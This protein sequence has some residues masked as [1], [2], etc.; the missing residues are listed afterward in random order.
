MQCKYG[1]KKKDNAPQSISTNDIGAICALFNLEGPLCRLLDLVP[2]TI[3]KILTFNF[4]SGDGYGLFDEIILKVTQRTFGLLIDQ[5]TGRIPTELFCSMEPPAM[6]EDITYS[7]VFIFMADLVPI[8]SNFFATNDV[9]SGNNTK[10]LDKIVAAWLRQQWFEHCECKAPPPVPD[11]NAY[12]NTP[13]TL[14]CGNSSQ[15]Q[16]VRDLFESINTFNQLRVSQ[17]KSANEVYRDTYFAQ[18]KPQAIAA[19]LA[20]DGYDIYFEDLADNIPPINTYPNTIPYSCGDV[21]VELTEQLDSKINRYVAHWTEGGQI[22]YTSTVPPYTNEQT[23]QNPS[24]TKLTWIEDCARCAPPI[25]SPV[26]D[27]NLFPK[28][29]FCALFPNDPL[30]GGNGDDDNNGECNIEYVICGEAVACFPLRRPIRLVLNVTGVDTSITVTEFASCANPR[31]TVEMFLLECVTP[32]INDCPDYEAALI[33]IAT[34]IS[35]NR[36][37]R[38]VGESEYRDLADAIYG[39]YECENKQNNFYIGEV[40]NTTYWNIK[41][42][43]PDYGCTDVFAVNYDPTA[44]HDDGSCQY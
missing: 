36:I 29:K 33:A 39:Q 21:F 16:A 13:P 32:V 44:S 42:A 24:S 14:R 17:A 35:N 5:L 15:S 6:P 28:D 9:L 30:C 25:P 26:L 11:S 27:G 3:Q 4:V 38:S 41:N 37:I 8:L 43:N 34:N 10:L 31:I 18:A 1:S 40:F 7:D 12:Q 23:V 19:I 20:R 22:G 2:E